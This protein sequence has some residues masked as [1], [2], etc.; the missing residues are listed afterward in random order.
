MSSEAN[1]KAYMDLERIGERVAVTLAKNSEIFEGSL[2]LP[3]TALMEGLVEAYE[4]GVKLPSPEL[5][6]LLSRLKAL[7]AKAKPQGVAE[8][9]EFLARKH[10]PVVI[11]E[12]PP[13]DAGA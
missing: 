3:K 7:E 6:E 9:E 12:G 2:V 4:L 10:V 5:D 8:M 11:E 1:R 13:P